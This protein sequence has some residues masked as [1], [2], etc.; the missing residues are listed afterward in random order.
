MA[1]NTSLT[2]REDETYEQLRTSPDGTLKLWHD[3]GENPGHKIVY[4]GENVWFRAQSRA[5]QKNRADAIAMI[6]SMAADIGTTVAPPVKVKGITIQGLAPRGPV[7][8]EALALIG[9]FY[10]ERVEIAMGEEMRPKA[11]PDRGHP[12]PQPQQAEAT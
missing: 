7:D 5:W 6:E 10:G 1:V 9:R 4:R 3:K 2:A 11:R 8:R 12:A